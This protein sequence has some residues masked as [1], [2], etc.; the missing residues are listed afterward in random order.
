VS[1]IASS[2]SRVGTIA[3]NTFLEAVRQR[4]FIAL[5]VLAAGLLASTEFLSEFNFGASEI[6]FIA[7]IGFGALVLFGSVLTI[8][9]TAQLF[10][11]E[12]ESRTA[13]T[14]LAKP[15]KRG[16]FIVGKFL[17]VWIVVLIFCAIVTAL[18]CAVLAIR[19]SEIIAAD[20]EAGEAL[21]SYGAL[22][23]AAAVQW[24]KFGV[25]GAITLLLGSFSNTN[26]FSVA[27][28]FLVLVICHLQYLARDVWERGASAVARGGAALLGFLFPNFQLFNLGDL[29]T[30]GDPPGASLVVRVSLY[31][32]V[33]IAVFLA[34]ASFS[35]RRREI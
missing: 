26:L 19:E 5:L 4:F 21:V 12:I 3:G 9:V 18:L 35:F 32:M 13:L 28:A 23:A 2:F 8:T 11:A 25:L 15:V 27:T 10:F 34:L 29:V 31:G 14:L 24:V 6:K 17:G 20:P 22:I 33:Y 1:G 30:S 16:E 7:D